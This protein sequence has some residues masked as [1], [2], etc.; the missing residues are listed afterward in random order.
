ME[1]IKWTEKITN[2]E[3]LLRV[4]EIRKLKETIKMRKTR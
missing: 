2:E 1:N 4:G 3:V